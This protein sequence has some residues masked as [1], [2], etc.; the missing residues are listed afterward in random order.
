MVRFQ[1]VVF[2]MAQAMKRIEEKNSPKAEGIEVLDLAPLAKLIR[3]E[4]GRPRR[5]ARA[6]GSAL[7]LI[8][9]RVEREPVRKAKATAAR[10]SAREM[11][12]RLAAEAAN[13]DR[14][15]TEAQQADLAKADQLE[16]ESIV[17]R[18]GA[19]LAD[20]RLTSAERRKVTA[21]RA[22]AF[23]LRSGVEQARLKTAALS[24]A[25]RDLREAAE[26]DAVREGYDGEGAV[27]RR[28]GQT[29]VRMR[30]RDG[31]KLMHERGGLGGRPGTVEADRLMAVGLRY[32]DRYEMA[33]TSLKS[34]LATSDKVKVERN[35]WLEAKA[36][37]KRAAVANG[38]RVMELKVA[39]AAGPEAVHVLRAVAGEG[40]T[41]SS[42]AS[43]TKERL[44]LADLLLKALTVL[45]S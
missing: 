28:R 21:L 1:V 42:L 41:V 14:A 16:A 39:G 37:H 18:A 27:E 35:V 19:V 12:R 25:E 36:A 26:L 8:A 4:A 29:A 40:R 32:R 7:A 38:V 45:A 31:L 20:R 34:C 23:G 22:T 10:K 33:A 5:M 2:E 11:R 3:L 43:K 44:A 24:A 17:I 15:L 30:L 13:D 9:H 6:L